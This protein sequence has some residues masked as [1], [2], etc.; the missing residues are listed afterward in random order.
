MYQLLQSRLE[1]ARAAELEIWEDEMAAVVVP[2]DRFT[3]T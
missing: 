3:M 2:Q 1:M